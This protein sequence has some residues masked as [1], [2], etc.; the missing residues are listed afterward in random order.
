MMN[1]K[2]A[3]LGATL[4]ISVLSCIPAFAGQWK[5]DSKGWWW[6]NDDGS[7]PVSTWQWIDGNQDGVAE[8]YYFGADGYMFVNITAPDGYSV[9]ADGAWII[10][11]TVQQRALVPNTKTNYDDIEIGSSGY[12]EN[13]NWIYWQ[14]K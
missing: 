1:K 7:Y 10:H 13:G 11:N 6:Q 3:V 5:Q 12:D 4:G 14:I 8:C 9:N 2:L